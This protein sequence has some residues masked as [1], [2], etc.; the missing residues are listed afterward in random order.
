MSKVFLSYSH[1]DSD[2]ANYI[3]EILGNNNID[4][5]SDLDIPKG[6]EWKKEIDTAIIDCFALVLIYTEN[7]K[8]SEYVTYEWS[9]AIGLGKTILPIQFQPYTNEFEAHPIINDRQYS[10]FTSR[11]PQQHEIDKLVKRIIE[12]QS[13]DEKQMIEQLRNDIDKD[14]VTYRTV[15]E[16][17]LESVL[18]VV[19]KLIQY[20]SDTKGS[21]RR[22]A[23][24]VLNHVN[25]DEMEFNENIFPLLTAIIDDPYRDLKV[26]EEAINVLINARSDKVK[27]KLL[28][29]MRRGDDL[30]IRKLVVESLWSRRRSFYAHDP[31]MIDELIELLDEP[32]ICEE[33]Q[34]TLEHIYED[35]YSNL[36]RRWVEKLKN[37]IIS[38]NVVTA[39]IAINLLNKIENKDVQ[40]HLLKLLSDNTTKIELKIELI[41]TISRKYGR[42]RRTNNT[43]P[44]ETLRVLISCLSDPSKKVQNAAQKAL[45]SNINEEILQDLVNILQSDDIVL[46]SNIVDLLNY[47]DVELPDDI[48]Q[49]LT[50]L[51]VKH[52]QIRSDVVDTL[53]KQGKKAVQPLLKLLSHQEPDIRYITADALGEIRSEEAVPQLSSLLQDE[54]L[55]FEGYFSGQNGQRVCD[56]AAWAL[57]SIATNEAIEALEVWISQQNDNQS[58]S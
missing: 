49:I 34:R 24:S 20:N 44:I 1:K 57:Y 17:K 12:L 30:A 48:I 46:I 2:L 54:V 16:M 23:V 11:V 36:K 10:D 45:R 19:E 38:E 26:K 56:A 51:L 47:G 15:R 18:G 13:D 55:T 9:F 35:L 43:L 21:V 50:G 41:E 33:A 25:V 37:K 3:L 31:D 27:N 22:N 4:V 14:N 58:A 42:F 5:W 8:K 28:I 53:V 7:A 29:Y 39:K 40:E 6:E 32:N 52:R